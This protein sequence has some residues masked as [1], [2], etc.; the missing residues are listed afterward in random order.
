MKDP[1]RD[2]IIGVPEAQV[3]TECHTEKN[4][5]MTD[6]NLADYRAKIAHTVGAG[7]HQ[8]RARLMASADFRRRLAAVMRL[9]CPRCL[10]GRVFSRF[11]T[12]R[13]SCPVCGHVF[14][15]E[16]GYFV[17]AMYVSYA[18]AIPLY[19]LFV[20]LLRPFLRGF[21]DLAGLAAGLP[22]VCLCAP[23]LFRYSRVIWMH[24]DWF[25]DPGA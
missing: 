10:E 8:E 24:F 25:F 11:L 15:R 18:L 3:C 20:A 1:R 14:E 5:E 13:D 4:S 6:H 16:P 7:G 12:M 22:L 9:R 2:N 19:L 23:F 17:G 21:S